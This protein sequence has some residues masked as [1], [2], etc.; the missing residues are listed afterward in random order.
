MKILKIIG[1]AVVAIIIA[2]LS[3]GLFVPSYEYQSSIKVN[4]SPERCWKVFH[5]TKLMNKWMNGFES[6]SLK[7]GDS[8]A[9]GSTYEIVVNGHGKRMVMIEMLTEINAPSKIS[10]QLTNNVLKTEFTFSFEGDSFTTITSHY[11]VSGS[12]IWWRSILFLSKS[13]MT[14]ESQD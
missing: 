2:A 7:S 10:Y 4:A 1:I 5:N 8:L 9:V 11:K 14:K 13:Y 12:N 6:L 3:I